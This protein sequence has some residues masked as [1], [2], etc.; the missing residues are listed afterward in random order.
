MALTPPENYRGAVLLCVE[1]AGVHF[2]VHRA[3]AEAV[4]AGHRRPERGG[5]PPLHPGAAPV[6]ALLPL[7]GEQGVGGALPV[8]G[9][10]ASSLSSSGTRSTARS[11]LR[12]SLRA[13]RAPAGTCGFAV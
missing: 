10:F 11:F 12:G 1:G 9:E 2:Q 6:R 13:A 4:L 7:A 8:P 3:V 5:V